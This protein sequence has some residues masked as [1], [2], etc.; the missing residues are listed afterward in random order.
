MT[1]YVETIESGNE[2]HAHL[3]TMNAKYGRG[4][5]YWCRVGYTY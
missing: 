4:S 1:D 5:A 2:F 3:I